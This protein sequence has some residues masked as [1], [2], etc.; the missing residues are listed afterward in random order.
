MLSGAP[1]RPHL[2]AAF[3]ACALGLLLLTAA[4][5]ADQSPQDVLT[6]GGFEQA[7]GGRPI[8]WVASSGVVAQSTTGVRSGVAAG[9]FTHSSR[10]VQSLSQF[11]TVE[12][13]AHYGLE[14]WCL[15]QTPDV[16]SAQ[17][18]LAWRDA[19][20]Q[21]L[22]IDQSPALTVDGV[23]HQLT[24]AERTPPNAATRVQA[25]VRFVTGGT[26]AT[27]YCDDLALWRTLPELPATSTPTATTTLAPTA[28]ATSTPAATATSTITPAA[29]GTGI[30]A[31]TPT[32]GATETGSAT[33]AS[34]AT[35]TPTFTH[36]PSIP[37]AGEM[38]PTPSPTITP[39]PS[40][41]PGSPS[42]T[43]VPTATGTVTPTLTPVIPTA[44]P[45]LQPA[46]AGPPTNTPTPLPTVLPPDHLVNGGFE[47]DLTPNGQR[48]WRPERGGLARTSANA[49]TGSA[50]VQ[51]TFSSQTVNAF[52]QTVQARP[53]LRYRFSIYCRAAAAGGL[54]AWA[55]ITASE[56]VDG[57]GPV[58]VRKEQTGRL[59]L[60]DPAYHL[61]D[62]GF[63]DNFPANGRSIRV[64]VSVTGNNGEAAITC[65]DA[66]LE[67]EAQPP[68]ATGTP[69]PTA[70]VGTSSGGNTVPA[71]TPTR[72]GTPTRTPTV[73]AT[74]TAT[75]TPTFTPIARD[76]V[77]ISE[78]MVN[79]A[80]TER[81][82]EWVELWHRGAGQ[83]HAEG[84]RLQDNQEFDPL[85]PFDLEP[86]QLALIVSNAETANRLLAA[87]AVVV[88]VVVPD[89]SIGNGLANGG[90]RLLLRDGAGQ[91]V[92]ALSWGDDTSVNRPACPA[93]RE[94]HSLQRR[95]D[96]GGGASCGF[97]DQPDPS[98]GLPNRPVPTPTPTVTRTP[99]R[100][101]TPTRTPTVTRTPRATVTGTPGA[102]AT[103]TVTPL[104]SQTA[105]PSVAPP[106]LP[107]PPGAPPA[108]VGEPGAIGD[109]PGDA[110]PPPRAEAD[111][112]TVG[113]A[114][115]PSG[116]GGVVAARLTPAAL[117]ASQPGGAARPGGSTGG[118][119]GVV[120]P[121]GSLVVD[122]ATPL[123]YAQVEALT[124]AP[125]PAPSADS[126]P[127]AALVLL[128]L[129]LGGAAGRW[130][131]RRP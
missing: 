76:Q 43:R 108:G 58:L 11:A 114:A 56:A 83:L 41:P 5:G 107:A 34:S 112:R 67:T 89:G 28:T 32:A 2:R 105:V 55:G 1:F 109:N 99:T 59:R 81:P 79:P 49:R 94:G 74:P 35:G 63:S 116:G 100:T 48:F 25:G 45:T 52:F 64:W 65:D 60:D 29:T 19:N 66:S 68:T 27:V 78:V 111:P 126:A 16:R 24:T 54:E 21:T 42:A 15:A 50:A 13:G 69:T 47:D 120:A 17:L 46:N 131:R 92:D 123:P 118:V 38:T 36:T 95:T 14:G 26:A 72:T 4:V 20:G 84:W 87:L 44:T 61:L 62:T 86:G 40:P 12:A 98:P 121:N 53:G 9:A 113:P 97:E 82:A 3:A 130:R 80:G 101:A 8:G 75:A 106:P 119:E 39:E 93:P 129:A 77:V 102:T 18:F 90:D 31:Q 122:A 103:P 6:N 85:P 70:T 37:P 22:A 128:A 51:F 96:G 23:Q 91:V 127:W 104:E 117:P 7:T 71:F 10:T 110:A 30:V 73:T 57:T 88:V 33:P 125:S 115:T 124:D